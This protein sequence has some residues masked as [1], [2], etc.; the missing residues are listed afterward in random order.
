[1]DAL[2]NELP[3]DVVAWA[4]VKSPVKLA[5]ID[6]LYKEEIKACLFEP[7]AHS[8]GQRDKDILPQLEWLRTRTRNMCSD[9][10]QLS[11]VACSFKL[12]SKGVRLG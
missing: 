1:M 10:K 8:K 7:K 12:T 9:S 4:S 11:P 2:K 5:L 3:L 6:T